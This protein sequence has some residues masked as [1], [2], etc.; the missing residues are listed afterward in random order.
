MANVLENP[1][2]RNNM[3]RYGY[4]M[5]QHVDFTSSVGQLIP[6]YYDLLYPGDKVTMDAT[7]LTRMQPMLTST[8]LKLKEHIDWFFVPYSQIFKPFESFIYGVNSNRTSLIDIQSLSAQLPK[9]SLHELYT[10]LGLEDVGGDLPASTPV[11][12]DLFG[13]SRVANVRRLFQALGYGDPFTMAFADAI[14]SGDEGAVTETGAISFS[15]SLLAAY[16]KIYY[17]YYRLEDRE[18]NEPFNYSLDQF[19]QRVD[20]ITGAELQ[21]FLELHYRPW[22]KDFFTNLYVSPIFAGSNNIGGIGKELAFD[23]KNWLTNYSAFF[24]AGA[25]NAVDVDDPRT[26]GM[27]IDRASADEPVNAA[28]LRLMFAV[29]KLMEVTRRAGKNYRDQTAAHFGFNPPKNDSQVYYLK[30]DTSDIGIG[31][32]TSTANTV[33]NVQGQYGDGSALGEIAGRG[34]GI[35]NGRKESF[36]APCHGF[37]MAIYSCVPDATYS[38]KGIDRINTFIKREDFYQPEFGEQ[39]MQPLFAEQF[40]FGTSSTLNSLVLGWQY[41]YMESKMKKDVCMTGFNGTLSYWIP[42][43]EYISKDLDS[44]L[45]PPYYLNSV[46]LVPYNGFDQETKE[47]NLGNNVFD[48][49]PLLH[50]FD[51]KVFKSSSMPTYGLPNL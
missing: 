4:D 45:I 25:N 3:S 12:S 27:Y 10:A 50:F 38:A 2:Y 8:P 47:D 1:V 34:F 26:T 42:R 35:G 28:N 51:M 48:T 29:D 36:T 24:P 7:M 13:S 19:Y 33:G 18:T 37:L 46:M 15:L 31:E 17:D 14:N 22:K 40:D 6:C 41:R 23:V 5:S 9:F 11:V 44:Y 39:G 16:Q 21:P 30:S 43:R 32:V 20:S 49:D